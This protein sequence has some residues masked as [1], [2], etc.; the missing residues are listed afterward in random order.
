MTKHAIESPL[1]K[2][3]TRPKLLVLTTSYPSDEIDPSG[4]FIA[5]LLAAL[6]RIGHQIKVIAPSNGSF[7]GRK[8]LNGI[9]TVRFGYFFPR[10]PLNRK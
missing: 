6:R 2:G 10:N 7:Y 5:K 1:K 4:I 9:D 3:T 8:L